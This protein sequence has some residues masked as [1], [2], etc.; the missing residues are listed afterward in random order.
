[1]IETCISLQVEYKKNLYSVEKLCQ[2]QIMNNK[3]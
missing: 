2:L 1:M 3:Y